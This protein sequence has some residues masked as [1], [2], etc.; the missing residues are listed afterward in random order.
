MLYLISCRSRKLRARRRRVRFRNGDDLG[1]VQEA[2]ENRGGGGDIA[3]EFASVFQ[4]R[5]EV[6][7]VE[8]TR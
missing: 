6:I 7:I 2:V 1:V 3:D 5:F 4:G 8:R